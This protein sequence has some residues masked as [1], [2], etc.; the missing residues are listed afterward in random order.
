MTDDSKKPTKDTGNRKIGQDGIGVRQPA[1]GPRQPS[2]NNPPKP[3]T[4]K[5]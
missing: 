3:D 1:L 5:K 2:R 4:N